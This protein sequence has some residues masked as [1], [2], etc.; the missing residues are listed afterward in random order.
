MRCAVSLPRFKGTRFA[1]SHPT[2]KLRS[3]H[4]LA[5]TTLGF[6]F[7]SS[8]AA[9]AASAP[10]WADLALE[11]SGVPQAE[12]DAL[13]R[14]LRTTPGLGEKISAALAGPR[15]ALA[16]DVIAALPLRGQLPRLLA[17]SARDTDY[18]L[19]LGI[20]SLLTRATV[21][22]VGD[23][24][25][26]RLSSST[27]LDPVST[28]VMLDAL[29]RMGRVLA[30]AALARLWRSDSYEVRGAVLS[31]IL[32]ARGSRELYQGILLDA[33]RGPVCQL[34]V[35]ASFALGARNP[36][37]VD[38][39]MEAR[40]P[41]AR[42]LHI[43]WGYKDARPARFVADT[44][45]RQ[46]FVQRLLAPCVTAGTLACGFRRSDTDSTL[47]ERTL[48]GEGSGSRLLRIRITASSAG[49]D[50]EQNRRNPFQLWLSRSAR[51]NF[52][53]GFRA[54]DAVFYNGH[55]R[56]GGGP[57]FGP[58]S[59]TS[60]GHVHYHRYKTERPGLNQ[61]LQRLKELGPTGTRAS[62]L[63]LFSCLS[64][65]YFTRRVR[66]IVPKISIISSSR[67]LYYEDALNDSFQALERA[68]REP[69]V[70]VNGRRS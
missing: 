1:L 67:L 34:R 18:R 2:V 57:D 51:R 29:S 12:H 7:L 10:P 45:E 62:V 26:R 35:Q 52:L 42:E 37:P 61:M 65:Q 17:L 27:A 50:D 60:S 59:L 16:L 11:L 36:Y 58:P 55:S 43:A 3:F 8:P 22:S 46:S 15:R 40:T 23:E 19:Y 20:N 28:V 13:V 64:D 63:G 38:C 49:P 56:D 5:R 70:T 31:T 33:L 54:A 4:L 47:L 25:L 69:E 48:G 9:S 21:S 53:D 68:L 39:A 30:P 41:A 24:Y 32:R 66:Q 14:K 6:A 44:Y